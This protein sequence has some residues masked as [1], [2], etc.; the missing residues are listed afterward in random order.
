MEAT[1]EQVRTAEGERYCSNLQNF[2]FAEA[3]DIDNFVDTLI[4]DILGTS[5]NVPS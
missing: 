5:S 2:I 1:M 4:L 3:I